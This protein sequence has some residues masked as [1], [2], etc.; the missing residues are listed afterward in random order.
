MP[1]VS[2]PQAPIAAFGRFGSGAGAGA[3]AGSGACGADAVASGCGVEGGGVVGAAAFDPQPA[4]VAT[5]TA[6]S[7]IFTLGSEVW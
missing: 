3:G 7:R 5:I 1:A 2:K 4:I 6:N